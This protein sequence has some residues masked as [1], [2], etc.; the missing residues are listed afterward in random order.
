MPDNKHDRSRSRSKSRSR[1]KETKESKQPSA[2]RQLLND[3]ERQTNEDEEMLSYNELSDEEEQQGFRKDGGKFRIERTFYND[4]AKDHSED[5]YVISEESKRKG[6]TSDSEEFNN[7]GVQP[8]ESEVTF[9]RKIDSKTS[10][11]GHKRYSR[12]K[13]DSK[14]SPRKRHKRRYYTTSESSEE[15]GI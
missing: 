12:M 2:K 4:K 11:R 1:G 6:N 15:D 13:K 10:E 3:F 7:F 9:K 8:V 5:D 14:T